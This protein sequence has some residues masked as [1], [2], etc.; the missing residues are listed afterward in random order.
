MTGAVQSLY[1]HI[2]FCPKKCDYCAFVTHVGSS[3]LIEPYVQAVLLEAQLLSSRH[4]VGPLETVYFGGGTPSMLD[5]EHI[6]SILQKIE[7]LFGLAAGVEITL[8]VHPAT[9]GPT[10]LREYFS[11]GVNRLSAGAESFIDSELEAL[12]RNHS[13]RQFLEFVV[14]ARDEGARNMN[15]DLMYGLPGQT[16]ASWKRTLQ[17]ALV[18]EL[19]HVSL[20]P[21]SIEPKTVFARKMRERRLTV[22]HDE[23]VVEM[24]H[25]A[26]DRLRE[27]GYVHYEVANWSK[28]G[29]QCAHNLTYWKNMQYVALGVGAHGYV[30]PIRTENTAGTK[31]Y[32]D[33]V[34]SGGDPVTE[35]IHLEPR[36]ELNEQLMLN[37]RLLDVG[38]DTTYLKQQFDFDLFERFGDEIRELSRAGLVHL[39]DHSLALD[40]HAV[41]VANDI[42]SLLVV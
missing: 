6:H 27:A 17:T 31:R 14:C 8:E 28:P 7:A 12:G 33:C 39:R 2:P 41:P 26:C 11:A 38:V 22:P 23:R 15:L 35:R 32:I 18:L 21:L 25:L 4:A 24:Y 9:A 5:G 10:K 29:K 19:E 40:E 34:A 36:D 1:I 3:R 13:S 20:Y 37:L 16:I 42:W 30:R